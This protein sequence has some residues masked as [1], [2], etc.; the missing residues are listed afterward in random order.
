VRGVDRALAAWQARPHDAR[1]LILSDFDGTLAEFQIDPNAVTLTPSS[2][3]L[4]QT[5]S[6]RADLSA[7]IVSGRRISDVRGRVPAAPSM[8]IAGLHGL[9]IEGPG[10]RFSHNGVA[11]AAPGL[12]F[13]SKDLRRA[14]KPLPGVFV[15]D[16]TY[17]VVL[18]VRGASKAD[19]LHAITRFTALSEPLL[20]EGKV[21]LQP[22][23]HVL[24]LLPNV[25]WAKG[26]AVRAIIRHVETHTKETV[27]PVYIGDDETDEDAFEEIG[28][29]GLT[30]AV[31]KRPAAA[32]FKVDNPAAVEG[33]L[34]A[35]LATE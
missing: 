7:G 16:K 15:E 6:T 34:K 13:L 31:G 30:I 11:L 8:F 10:F 24:E 2:K 14:V 5:L 29:N 28:T 21:R 1:P 23:D 26:D 12:S 18:H 4:L 33:F 19:R 35:I 25:D 22:G 32:A 17:A 3:I 27:W 20:S 9:E